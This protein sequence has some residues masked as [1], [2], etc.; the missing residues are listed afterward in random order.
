MFLAQIR[1]PDLTSWPDGTYYFRATATNESGQH[2]VSEVA[3]VLKEIAYIRL[4]RWDLGHED[5]GLINIENAGC[6]YVNVEFTSLADIDSIEFEV[7][8]DGSNWT[9]IDE[10]TI[11]RDS[12]VAKS[13]SRW[14]REFE[15]DATSWP[16]G[17]IY[18]KVT[19]TDREERSLSEQVEIFKDTVPPEDVT[20]FIVE[21]NAEADALVLNWTNPKISSLCAYKE[22]MATTMRTIT[23]RR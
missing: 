4:Q 20:N 11:H 5:E 13:H 2:C 18:L 23:G 3:E 16:E 19:A 22:A 9:P 15:I 10:E 6:F 12:D 8:S 1:Y 7:S 17:I 14:Y 21:P